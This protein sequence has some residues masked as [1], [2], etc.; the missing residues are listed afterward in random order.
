MWLYDHNGRAVLQAD[1][2]KYKKVRAPGERSDWPVI[3]TD[4]LIRLPMD[5]SIRSIRLRLKTPA[6][7]TDDEPVTDVMFTRRIPQD[8]ADR[9]PLEPLNR[10]GDQDL[11]Q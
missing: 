9:R 7:A 5:R 11:P 4:I 8:I 3:P 2:N 10:P 1:L 6:L